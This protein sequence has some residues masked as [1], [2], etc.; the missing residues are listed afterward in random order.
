MFDAVSLFYRLVLE[1]GSLLRGCQHFEKLK[2]LW[3]GKLVSDD[4]I[5]QS[6]LLVFSPSAILSGLK[7]IQGEGYDATKRRG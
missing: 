7:E 1:F 4:L 5:S 6:G 2:W 3:T